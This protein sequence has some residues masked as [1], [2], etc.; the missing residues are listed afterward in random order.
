MLA[1]FK[2]I[3]RKRLLPYIDV[4]KVREDEYLNDIG[5]TERDIFDIYVYF[6]DSLNAETELDELLNAET[7]KDVIVFLYIYWGDK[8]KP[9]R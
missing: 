2:D 3:I 8:V 4:Y 6:K 9:G 7:V 5:V 1:T